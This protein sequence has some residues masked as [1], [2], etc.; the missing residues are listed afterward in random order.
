MFTGVLSLSL[1]ST[2]A[3]T[4]GT[5]QTASLQNTEVSIPLEKKDE[6]KEIL[7]NPRPIIQDWK[8]RLKNKDTQIDTFVSKS[9]S[10]TD[11][12]YEPTDLVSVG[13]IAEISEAGR[14]NKIRKVARE[15]LW[16]MARDFHITF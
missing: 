12:N 1:I 16:S 15:S 6:K 5:L 2:I 14:A 11:K 4:G 10:L 3:L 8:T 7:K 13:G 9:I